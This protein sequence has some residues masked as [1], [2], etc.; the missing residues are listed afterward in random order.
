EL[1]EALWLCRAGWQRFE[2]DGL[3][4]LAPHAPRLTT[5][6]ARARWTAGCWSVFT[7]VTGWAVIVAA[8]ASYPTDNLAPLFAILIY[9]TFAAFITT[10]WGTL[11]VADDCWVM[12]AV[13]FPR[14]LAKL[15]LSWAGFY[16]PLMLVGATMAFGSS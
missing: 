12:G 3:I 4:M 1:E 7:M 16:A 6:K 10:A 14:R 13:R 15:T 11:Y 5:Y 8:L 9:G 2:G